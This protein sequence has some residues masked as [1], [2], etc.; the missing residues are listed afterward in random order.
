MSFNLSA[1]KDG[2]GGA[3]RLFVPEV[4]AASERAFAALPGPLIFWTAHD[5]QQFGGA[6]QAISRMDTGQREAGIITPYPHR[7]AFY[8]AAIRQR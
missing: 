1:V 6:L 8:L 4:S 5:E 2:G 7:L 3:L